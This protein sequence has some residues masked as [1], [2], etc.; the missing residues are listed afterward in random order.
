MEEIAQL[1]SNAFGVKEYGWLA[2][3]GILLLTG[4]ATSVKKVREGQLTGAEALRY[5]LIIIGALLFFWLLYWA[6]S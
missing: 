6:N 1:I 2:I 5:W 4:I 3:I